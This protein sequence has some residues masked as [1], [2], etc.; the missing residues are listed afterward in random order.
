MR[1]ILLIT[2]ALLS[3]WSGMQAQLSFRED[4]FDY[5]YDYDHRVVVRSCYRCDE[6]YDVLWNGDMVK[7]INDYI[8]IYRGHDRITWGDK[9]WLEHNGMYTVKRG[10]YMYLIDEDGD[11]TGVSGN[12]INLLWDGIADVTRGSVHYLYKTN[13][14]RFGNAF[15]HED[16]LIYWNGWY[17]VQVNGRYYVADTSGTTQYS[18]WSDVM[19][20]L[21][22]NECFRVERNG[23]TYLV[24][25]DGGLIH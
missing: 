25:T 2:L 16:I 23:W 18:I 1:R 10:G 11:M 15:S 13:G 4:G 12:V 22:A 7:V 17:G 14:N 5:L 24:D 21:M 19:P 8:Y 20:E 6:N 3:V 9:V